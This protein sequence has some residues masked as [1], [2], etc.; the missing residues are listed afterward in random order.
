VKGCDSPEKRSGAGAA[1]IFRPGPLG[2]GFFRSEIHVVVQR[3]DDVGVA[4]DKELQA[5]A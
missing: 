3:A 2:P 5:F 1:A 4:D